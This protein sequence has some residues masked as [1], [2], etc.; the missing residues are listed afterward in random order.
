MID[1]FR[2]R[3]GGT[4]W[5][6]KKEGLFRPVNNKLMVDE[7]VNR[8][9]DQFITTVGGSGNKKEKDEARE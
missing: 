8:T 3:V 9:D 5:R 1:E 7:C 2:R 4:S 6:N